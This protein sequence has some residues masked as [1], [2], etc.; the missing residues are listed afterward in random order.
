LL[1]SP[2][3]PP[4]AP[5]LSSA[6]AFVLTNAFVG[7]IRAMIMRDDDGGPGQD[8][9]EETLARLIAAFLMTAP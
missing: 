6:E 5:S 7:V 3:R 1:A 4:A 8:E 2:N 9:I